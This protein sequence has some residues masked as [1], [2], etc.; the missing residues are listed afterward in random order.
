MCPKCERWHKEALQCEPLLKPALW[1][2]F[3]NVRPEGLEWQ[4]AD[5][6]MPGEWRQIAAV[7]NA[8]FM[9]KPATASL[10]IL[11]GIVEG[12]PIDQLTT[13]FLDVQQQRSLYEIPT[14]VEAACIAMHK[15]GDAKEQV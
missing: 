14:T 1:T 3:P 6:G 11:G 5:R 13:F 15:W 4:E 2:R 10:L 8:D 9:V 12:V 7:G